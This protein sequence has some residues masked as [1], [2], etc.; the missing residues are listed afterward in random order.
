[1][2]PITDDEVRRYREDGVVFLPDL[3]DPAWLL[4]MRA[5]Y[6]QEMG[7]D[8]HGLVRV[9]V[10][11]VARI[12]AELGFEVLAGEDQRSTGRFEVRTFNW[13]QFPAVAEL[14]CQ[15]PMP[16]AIARLLGAARINF[17]G[18]QLFLKEAGSLHRTAFH[19]DA[20]YFH[21]T[22]DQCCTVWMPLDEVDEDNGM[23][24]YVPRSHLWPVHAANTFASQAPIPGSQ[25]PRL[26]DI[27]G[28][29]DE[30]GVV[31]FPAKP[32]DAI[33]HHVRTVHGSTGNVG[34][35]DRRAF[36]LRYAGDDVRYC[37]RDGAPGDSQRSRTLVEGDLLDSPEFPLVWS[38]ETGYLPVP[39][40][41]T[42]P[43]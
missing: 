27:E 22:G 19:Q 41:Q 31:Y 39:P 16:Q 2:R 6:D 43:V 4:K 34:T 20:P 42:A 24:G 11:E 13:R 18:E 36:T 28:R 40:E 10:G 26:P 29:E 9:D 21:I 35:R 12:V 33:V 8:G 17:F 32:G 5:A 30:F 23:M 15:A 7:N 3:L 38:A 14:G 25:L 1:M 37:E